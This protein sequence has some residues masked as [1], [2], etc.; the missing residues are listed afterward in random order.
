[1]LQAFE[2]ALGACGHDKDSG[3]IWADY[4]EFVK[5]WPKASPEDT[6]T[7]MNKLREV[8][9][10]ALVIPLE[11]LEALWRDYDQYENSLNRD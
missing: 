8:Y 4:I 7:Q 5:S 9:H 11:N 10:R 1:M 3:S 6:K 2:F